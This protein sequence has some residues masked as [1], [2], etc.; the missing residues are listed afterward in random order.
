MLGVFVYITKS[1]VPLQ[2]ATWT[3]SKRDTQNNSPFTYYRLETLVLTMSIFMTQLLKARNPPKTTLK[4]GLSSFSDFLLQ[5]K[6]SAMG[7]LTSPS[8][9]ELP[10]AL[11]N[12]H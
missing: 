1:E 2:S 10:D 9:W 11:G 3:V 5:G 6:S 12:Q 8:P 7:H 4:P